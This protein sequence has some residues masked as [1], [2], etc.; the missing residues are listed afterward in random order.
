MTPC[1]RWIR[2]HLICPRLAISLQNT[3][4]KLSEAKQLLS[5][6]LC[7][8]CSFPVKRLTKIWGVRRCAQK[9]RT[10]GMLSWKRELVV[11]H[12]SYLW[13]LTGRLILASS[14]VM[15]ETCSTCVAFHSQEIS[16][17]W[18]CERFLKDGVTDPLK[19]AP[20]EGDL[21]RCMPWLMTRPL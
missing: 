1:K 12:T 21:R 10:T 4:R 16:D 8:V 18:C 9:P 5:V 20:A 17:F 11:R 6:S 7:R 3:L 2:L 13:R 19:K 15:A 14:F